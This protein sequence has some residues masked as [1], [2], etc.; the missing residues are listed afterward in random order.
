MCCDKNIPSSDAWED[1][2]AFENNAIMSLRSLIQDNSDL[3]ITDL[4]RNVNFLLQEAKTQ[5]DIR[6]AQIYERIIHELN[7]CSLREFNDLKRA[8]WGRIDSL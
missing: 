8:T 7:E 2:H 6:L 1:V 3:E 4:V 5:E